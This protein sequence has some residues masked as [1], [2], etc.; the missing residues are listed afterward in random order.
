MSELIN[1]YVTHEELKWLQDIRD[2]RAALVYPV[3]NRDIAFEYLASALRGLEM[4]PA[5]DPG[6]VNYFMP[7]TITS[8]VKAAIDAIG[9]L[10]NAELVVALQEIR[11]YPP[12]IPSAPV[13]DAVVNMRSIARKA[14]EPKTK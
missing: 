10:T 6:K 13:Q 12:D 11:D 2:R 14:L 4:M 9:Q 5:F 1:T 8:R 3:L 7:E